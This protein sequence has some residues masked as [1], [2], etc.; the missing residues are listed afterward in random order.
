MRQ[1]TF[2]PLS[3]RARQTQ[4]NASRLGIVQTLPTYPNYICCDAVKENC[5]PRANEGVPWNQRQAKIFFPSSTSFTLF[6]MGEIT[7]IDGSEECWGKELVCNL[8]Q[9]FVRPRKRTTRQGTYTR[10]S[11]ETNE[12]MMHVV[13][14][15]YSV[16]NWTVVQ[17]SQQQQCSSIW[18]ARKIWLAQV[19]LDLSKGGHF[20]SR[21]REPRQ[22]T[23]FAGFWLSSC[24]RKEHLACSCGWVLYRTRR[25]MTPYNQAIQNERN[26]LALKFEKWRLRWTSF[27]AECWIVFGNY[28]PLRKLN[29]LQLP[30]KQSRVCEG[31]KIM[32]G[33]GT[34]RWRHK[35]LCS[36]TY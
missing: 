1:A 14:A 30:F 24:K 17:S 33:I 21:L 12:C 31:V 10:R 7:A 26:A 28:R 18:R 9:T 22:V 29:F 20:L 11:L 4:I 19:H 13:H 25:R 35:W 2:S 8:W 16:S 15:V 6:K 34:F 36:K 27:M 32:T 5:N 3:Q 23:H